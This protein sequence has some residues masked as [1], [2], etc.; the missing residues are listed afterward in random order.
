[1]TTKEKNLSC[2]TTDEGGGDASSATPPPNR[3]GAGR[4]VSVRSIITSVIAAVLVVA[5]A[6]LGWMLNTKSDELSSLQ[7]AA[8]NDT[9]AEDI[10]SNY[11]VGAAQMDF[12]KTDEWKTRLVAGT[13]PELANRL[14]QAATSMEQITAPLQWTSTSTPITATVRSEAD[15]TYVVDC[16]V[17]VVTKNNQAPEGVQSTAT[18]SVTIDSANNWLIT[19]VGGIGAMMEAK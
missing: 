8:A 17:N 12:T 6:V 9:R 16:F 2:D 18:Y 13:S 15:G 14:T 10:A 4:Q 11:A 5:I 7:A 19:D 3:L 1:M